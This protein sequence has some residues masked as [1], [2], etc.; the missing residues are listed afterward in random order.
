MIRSGGGSVFGV[1]R[2]SP[3]L[4]YAYRYPEKPMLARKLV[5]TCLLFACSVAYGE[6]IRS[7]LADGYYICEINNATL[8]KTPQWTD[9]NA[10]PPL[11][12]VDAIRLATAK[13]RG[14]RE[15]DTLVDWKLSSVE[16]KHTQPGG[17]FYIATF[18]SKL[19]PEPPSDRGRI[20][21]GDSPYKKPREL[22]IPVF[23]NGEI[24]T[25]IE[26]LHS[27]KLLKLLNDLDL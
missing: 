26:H 24:P 27:D 12:V 15:N 18:R 17:W 11:S 4:G 2:L 25:L 23:M 19:R 13:C 7:D 20:T 10:P 6:E 22:R 21:R 16:L 14:L 1:D 8:A 3:P 9:L 5:V